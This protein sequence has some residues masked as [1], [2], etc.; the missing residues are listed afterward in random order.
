MFKVNPTIIYVDQEVLENLADKYAL[1]EYMRRENGTNVESMFQKWMQK[2]ANIEVLRLPD[3][4]QEM[5]YLKFWKDMT[6]EEIAWKLGMSICDVNMTLASTLTDLKK[7]IMQVLKHQNRGHMK[8][9]LC[10]ND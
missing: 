6:D 9:I 4:S 1:D 3:R 5:L 2:I 7:N 8:E 10:L